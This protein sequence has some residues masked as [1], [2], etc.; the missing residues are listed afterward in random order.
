MIAIKGKDFKEQFF[1]MWI[2]GVLLFVVCP[3]GATQS[4][5]YEAQ[6]NLFFEFNK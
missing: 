5:L 2:D 3:S 4:L 6:A 1:L